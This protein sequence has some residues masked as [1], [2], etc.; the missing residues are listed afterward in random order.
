MNLSRGSPSLVLSLS[1]PAAAL[2]PFFFALS[3]CDF[4]FLVFT[5]L[6]PQRLTNK[7]PVDASRF[8]TNLTYYGP[9]LHRKLQDA[10]QHSADFIY[11][12]IFFRRITTIDI[13]MSVATCSR[14]SGAFVYCSTFLFLKRY[15]FAHSELVAYVGL[16]RFY[17][18]KCWMSPSERELRAFGSFVNLPQ[19]IINDQATQSYRSFFA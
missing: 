4:R 17:L 7:L 3:F 1:P 10:T 11:A 12:C 13:Y 9:F 5:K 16:Y 2:P 18:Q 6:I 14:A 8:T 19:R 15:F